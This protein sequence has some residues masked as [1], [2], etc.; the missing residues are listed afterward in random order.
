VKPLTDLS[1]DA[2]DNALKFQRPD[3]KPLVRVSAEW[4]GDE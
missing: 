1:S 3:Q 4:L 2:L